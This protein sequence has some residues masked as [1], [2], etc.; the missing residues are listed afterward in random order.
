MM[1]LLMHYRSHRILLAVKDR[2]RALLRHLVEMV[3]GCKQ[4]NRVNRPNGN[5]A[6]VPHLRVSIGRTTSPFLTPKPHNLHVAP[7]VVASGTT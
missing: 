5:V 7:H 2:H 3:E 4:G 1:V 6:R